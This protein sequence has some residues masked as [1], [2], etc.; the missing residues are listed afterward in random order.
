VWLCCQGCAGKAK[1]APDETLKK[2][3]AA[4]SAGSQ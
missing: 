4:E 1:R 3:A 2:I